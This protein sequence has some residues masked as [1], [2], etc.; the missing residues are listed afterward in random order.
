MKG[1]ILAGGHGTRLHP[2]TLGAC[3]QL[4]PIYDKPMIYYPL[5]VLMQAGI[6][7]ILIISTAEDLPRFQR[8]FGSGSELGLSFSYL[9]QE[10]P[11][12]IAHAFILGKEFIK[13]D[14]VALVLGD[15]IFYG[16]ALQEILS[17]CT[18]LEKGAIIFGYEVKD[19]HR[20][21]VVEFDIEMKVTRIIEKPQEPASRFAV[22][23]LYFYDN[24]V[25]EI[26][27]GL[28][29]SSRGEYEITDINMAY[30]QRG[31][32]HLRILDRG[33]AWLDTGTHEALQQAAS[34]VQTIQMRQGIKIACIE[35][36][37]YRM[38]FIDASKLQEFADRYSKNEYGSYLAD[39]LERNVVRNCC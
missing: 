6:R 34:Y 1:I 19:P 14:S 37:A 10:K 25:V 21:G 30:L 38:G 12:G 33:F 22:T 5:S 32:L 15:N 27:R 3:K 26:A 20:Y 29:P 8:I 2:V 35:E 13:E 39:L 18:S 36:I 7:E 31:D 17:T 4:L 16:H 28:L 9:V 23:G 24:D 11:E